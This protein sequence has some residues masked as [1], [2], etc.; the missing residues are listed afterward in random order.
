MYCTMKL[1]FGFCDSPR[2]TDKKFMGNLFVLCLVFFNVVPRTSTSI[3]YLK[4]I[5]VNIDDTNE[6]GRK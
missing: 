6:N 5:N 2:D 4:R 1:N 3:S